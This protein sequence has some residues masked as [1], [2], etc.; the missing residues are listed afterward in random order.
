MK[1]NIR[2][3]ALRIMILISALV[4][5][6]L[7]CG[8]RTR[9]TNNTEVVGVISDDNG[10]LQQSYQVRRDE[11]GI[12]VAE[13]PLFT[14]FGSEDEDYDG[15]ED[16]DEDEGFDSEDEDVTDEDEDSDDEEEPEQQPS[17][18]TTPST[19]PGTSTRPVSRTPVRRPSTGVVRRPATTQTT[20]VKV[21][22]Y[23]NS[24]DAKCS[25]TS[26]SV[27]K[28]S[29]YG[30]LPTPTRS[31]YDFDGW[32]TSKTKGSKVTSKTKVKTDKAHSL[33][34]HWT[35]IEAKTYTI[36]FD[37]NGDGDEVE[38]SSTEITVKEGGTY[39][40]L[41]SAKRDKYKFSGWFTEPTGGSQVTSD[42]KFKANE[43]QTLYAQWEE[44]LYNWWNNEF[45]T[46]VNDVPESVDVVIDGGGSTS[47]KKIVE[48]CKG[49][50]TSDITDDSIILKF[51]D[52]YTEDK[53]IEEAEKIHEKINSTSGDSGSEDEGDEGDEGS[54]G[55]INPTIIII[56]SDA[57]EGSDEQKLVYKIALLDVLHGGSGMD[58]E[59]VA[60]DLDVDIYY[61]YTY[62]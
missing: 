15:D 5:M 48:A 35:K 50:V 53:A 47:K 39:G 32:Y 4:L 2:P 29:T 20:Y 54:G 24:K 12:P 9:I 7:L 30:A 14:G 25:R 8:C 27:R 21:T 19:T 41:P 36:T 42:T 22:L 43:D 17:T 62:Q 57:V 60:S 58:Y 34:A 3:Y 49:N 46:A 28:G 40:K 26:L 56:S 1:K 11:L 23:L 6:M 61:P 10:M 31:G 44:D 38:L 13:P 33:Y 16:Y 59:E 45:K 52:E 51:L 55:E 37:G 18:S